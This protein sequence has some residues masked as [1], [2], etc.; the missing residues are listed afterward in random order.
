M[1]K[2]IDANIFIERWSNPD[3]KAFLDQ[4]NPEEYCT[5]VL[6]L[7]E[8]SHKLKKKGVA[9]I[10]NITRGILGTMKVH[11]ILQEDLFEAIKIPL[12]LQIN[13]KIHLA[14]MK[15][16][17]IKTIISFDKDF[18]QDKSIVREEV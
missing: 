5:S 3:V 18:D 13:D 6:V 8:V 16:N 10:F 9:N 2:F 1:I 4:I 17:G 11:D 12:D 7:A 15:R 14:V